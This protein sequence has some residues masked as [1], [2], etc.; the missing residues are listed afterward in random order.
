MHWS[1]PSPDLSTA[2][3]PDSFL[4]LEL[5]PTRLPTALFVCQWQ[6]IRAIGGRRAFL[7]QEQDPS[8]PPLPLGR[9]NRTLIRLSDHSAEQFGKLVSGIYR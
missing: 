3:Q 4:A 1:S 8:V 6:P 9:L 7:L 2:S 5:R